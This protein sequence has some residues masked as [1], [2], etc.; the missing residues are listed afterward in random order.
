M[1]RVLLVEDDPEISRMVEQYLTIEGFSVVCAFDGESVIAFTKKSSF[2]MIILDLMLPGMDGMECLKQIRSSSLI[3]VLILSAKGT[4]IDKAIGLGFGADDYLTKPFSMTE[5]VARVKAL[6]RRAS[7]CPVPHSRIVRTKGMI[8]DPETYSVHKYDQ[9]IQ[10]TLKEFQILH[11]LVT[12]RNK[13]FTK[14][15][16]YERVWNEEYYEDANIIN[17]HMSRLRE[18]IEDAP[19]SPIYIKTVWGIGYKWG[20]MDIE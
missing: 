16:I 18:K 3:P 7:Y 20:E 15:E 8:I 13:V 12:H 9:M 19:S 6:L 17:V 11:L 1:Q 5:L 4:E 2:A 10:L 14:E